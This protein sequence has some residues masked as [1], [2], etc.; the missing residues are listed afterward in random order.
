MY[1]SLKSGNSGEDE[2]LIESFDMRENAKC[3]EILGMT[4]DDEPTYWCLLKMPEK[5]NE[6]PENQGKIQNA[7][8]ATAAMK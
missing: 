3:A 1:N 7:E 8:K 5:M 4:A 6:K 2:M